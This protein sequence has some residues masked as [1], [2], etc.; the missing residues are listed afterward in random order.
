MN[1]FIF[2]PISGNHH[3][4]KKRILLSLIK[5]HAENIVF[6]TKQKNDEI[7]LTQKAIELGAK[8][9]IAV[10]GDGTINKVASVL[11]GRDIPLGLIPMG[12]GNGLARHLNIPLKVEDAFNKAM[13]GAPIKID[14]CFINDKEFFCTSGIGFDA[15][16]A[17][18]FEHRKKRGIFNYFIAVIISLIRYKPIHV[19][20]NEGPLE[21]L[22]LLTISNANQYGNNA[23]ISPGADIQDGQFEIVKI[24]HVNKL[25]LVLI[26]LRLFLKNI[27][28]SSDV[29]IIRSNMASI[30]FDTNQFMHVDGESMRTDSEYLN[31]TIKPGLLHVIV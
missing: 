25:K 4:D 31:I 28:L 29:K 22:F 26:G 14:V 13:N 3:S 5:S 10:G 12:S 15:F 18:I 9:I 17:D 11:Y 1:Y 8:K 20:V 30:K 24:R 21:K 16:V 2:N 7:S 27:H 6:E 19:S 23:F